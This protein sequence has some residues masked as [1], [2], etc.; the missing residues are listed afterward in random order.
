M[1][2][3]RRTG[4]GVV[5]DDPPDAAQYVR[6]SITTAPYRYRAVVRVDAPIETVAAHVPP[7]VGWLEALDAVT[8]RLTAGADALDYLVVH[9]GAMGLDFVVV[10]DRLRRAAIAPVSAAGRGRRPSPRSTGR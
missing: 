2:D 7:S 4:H 9:L 1:I 3:V 5:F 10:A 6:E 8:T